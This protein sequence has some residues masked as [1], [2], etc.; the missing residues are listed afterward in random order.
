MPGEIVVRDQRDQQAVSVR[1]DPTVLEII[2]SAV[3]DERVDPAKLSALLDLK[4]R[5]D[6]IEAEGEFTRAFARMH[7]TLP[8]IRKN[9]KVDMGGKGSYSFARWDDVDTIVGPILQEHG[10]TLAFTSRAIPAGVLMICTLSHSAGHS[11]S[12]E[13]QLPPDSGA[14]RNALQAIGSARSYGKRYLTL[15][16][17][18]LTTVDMD[19]DARSVGF[20]TDQQADS[21]MDLIT[22][23]GLD[24]APDRM[25]KF[26]EFMRAKSV[27]EIHASD[28]RRAITLL[29]SARRKGATR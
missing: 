19:D 17:L 28:Y 20:V 6:A 4:V 22:E 15:D 13:M 25:S 7:P 29:E 2:Q 8:R 16:I 1:H 3:L 12:S 11:R 26:L 14:G 5:M 18:N 27:S 23:C 10:F 24:K 9:G 21:I